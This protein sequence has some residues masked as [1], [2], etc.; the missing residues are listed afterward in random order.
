M[1]RERNM[2]KA[3]NQQLDAVLGHKGTS[4]DQAMDGDLRSALEFAGKMQALC[5]KPAPEYK[6]RLKTS[7]LQKIADAEAEKATGRGWLSSLLQ[8]PVMRLATAL[9]LIALVS[10][11]L[12][13]GGVFNRGGTSAPTPGSPLAVSASTSK[14]SYGAGEAVLINVSLTNVTAENLKIE[15][16]P[17][18]LSLMDA[19]TKQ[20]VY[21]F[22]AGSGTDVLAPSQTASFT[23]SW[24]QRDERGNYVASGRYY[25]ELEDLYY[26]GHAVKLAP[27][28][29]VSF[30]ILPVG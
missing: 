23:L 9:V 16:Y 10:T 2:E 17:P 26:Q 8:Q 4:L 1:D 30:N 15:Q 6:N 28:Q 12:W 24:D 21:T 22:R 25:I 11:G 7:L 5:V 20:A 14:A 19:D 29:P 18:I 13:A 3:F 27:T